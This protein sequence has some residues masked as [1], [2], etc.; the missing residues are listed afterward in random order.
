MHAVFVQMLR[1]GKTKAKV[2]EWPKVTG[3]APAAA[4]PRAVVSVDSDGEEVALAPT[5]QSSFSDAIKTAL[6]K[7]DKQPGADVT[8]TSSLQAVQQSTG[9]KKKN[10]KTL[11]F[12]TSLP[13]S[14]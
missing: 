1:A 4:T 2:A 9:K 14:K 3:D 10:K 6:D 12:T 13:R 8:V 7:Y 11:L 5:F